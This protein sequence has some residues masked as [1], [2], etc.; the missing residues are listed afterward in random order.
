MAAGEGGQVL[1]SA[2]EIVASG[3]APG[4]ATVSS[5]AMTT[6]ASSSLAV[7]T[8]KTRNFR[9]LIFDGSMSATPTKG[10]AIEIYERALNISDTTDDANTPDTAYMH[11]YVGSFNVD[12]G[13]T[14][15]V[16]ESNPI[17]VKPYDV[18]Y[19]FFANTISVGIA[20]TWTVDAIHWSYNASQA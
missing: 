16:L 1:D 14:A 11:R 15:Q 4:N 2:V 10:D 9:T 3:S 5:G 12:S 7:A 19:Y 8:Y 20:T 17:P 6:T 13:G 18:E